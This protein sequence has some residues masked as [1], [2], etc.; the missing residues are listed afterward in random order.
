MALFNHFW[1][2]WMGLCVVILFLSGHAN[3]AVQGVFAHYMVGG[4]SSLDQA[5]ADVSGAQSLGLDAFALN[6]QQPDAAWT[7]ASLSLLFAAAAQRNFKLFFSLDMS[8]IASPE[9]TLALL[10]AYLTH[11]AYYHHQSRPFLSTFHIGASGLPAW[12]RMLEKLSPRPFFV[13]NLDDHPS[14]RVGTFPASLFTAVSVLDGIMGWESAWPFSKVP[15]T[16]DADKTNINNARAAKKAYMMPLSTFQSKHHAVW[17]NWYRRGGLTLAEHAKTALEMQP[18]F[19]EVLTWNDAGEGHYVGNIWPEALPGEDLSGYWDHGGWKA[20]LRP[21]V[22]ALKGGKGVGEVVPVGGAKVQGGFWY[23]PLLKVAECGI[24]RLGLGKPA[25]W[26]DAEDAVNVMVAVGKGVQGARVGV[27]SGGRQVAVFLA[28]EGMN[29]YEV[30]IRKGEQRVEVV[31]DGKVVAEGKGK[32]GV[33]DRVA[34]LGGVCTFN[35][36]VAEIV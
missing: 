8:C 36:Q 31:I 24:D 33:T 25:G 34:D 16:T 19:V 14:A 10:T 22:A 12:Q 2:L 35:Y 11:P 7:R 9:T 17:G 6:V 32:M 26:E 30:P 20:V 3:A 21:V 27:Y 28:M 15:A 18:E 13:P 5:L 4:M 23:R 1:G 29:S